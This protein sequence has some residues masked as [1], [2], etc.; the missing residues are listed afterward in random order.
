MA[1]NTFG[2]THATVAA[3]YFPSWAGGFSASSR[4]TSTTV[5]LVVDESAAVLEGR[6]YAENITA[7]AITTATDAAYLMCAGQLRRMTA[8]RIM[9]ELTQQNPD[10]AKALQEEID[11][12]FVSLAEQGGTF[13]GNDAL[14]SGTSDP[15][16]PTTHISKYSLTV[17]VAADMSSTVPTLRKDDA[18]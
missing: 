12:W 5:G 17:D 4:P 8:L 16:G 3:M 7:S 2:V 18:L 11:A 10:V 14:N 15:D 9:R 13:L 6:L 1:V